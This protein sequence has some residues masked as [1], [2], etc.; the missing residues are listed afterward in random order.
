MYWGE[1]GDAV[2]NVSRFAVV[3]ASPYVAVLAVATA[4]TAPKAPR[5]A[6]RFVPAAFAAMHLGWGIGFFEGVSRAR[7]PLPPRP[8]QR[9]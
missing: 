5:G 9:T 4:V 1:S 6:R 2:M 7:T 3:M 8:P